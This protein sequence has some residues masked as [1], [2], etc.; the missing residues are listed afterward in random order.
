MRRLD[1]QD[2]GDGVHAIGLAGAI[3]A[4]NGG[5]VRVSKEEDMLVAI[6]LEV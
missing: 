5:E 3:G 1:S 2:E 4:N 6:R